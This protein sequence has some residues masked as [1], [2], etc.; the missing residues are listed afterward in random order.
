MHILESLSSDPVLY[1]V[2][3]NT[4][5]YKFDRI[6]RKNSTRFFVKMFELNLNVFYGQIYRI[7][8]SEALKANVSLLL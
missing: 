6:M 5:K 1:I 4:S 2:A 8:I 7:L 3:L